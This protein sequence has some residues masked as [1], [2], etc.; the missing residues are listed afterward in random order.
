MAIF[1]KF[2]D[3]SWDATKPSRKPGDE[4]GQ[5]E[6][7]RSLGVGG[8][9]EVYLVKHTLQN[10]Y[11]AL[12]LFKSEVM[13]KQF[14][15]VKLCLQEVKICSSIRHQ[16]LVAVHGAFYDDNHHLAYIV[17][18]YIEGCSLAKLIQSQTLTVR[19]AFQMALGI[20]EALNELDKHNYAHCDVKPENIMMGSKGDIKL[21]DFGIAGI[22]RQNQQALADISYASLFS[23]SPY[24]SPELLQNANAADFRSDIFS[25]GATLYHAVSGQRP[26]DGSSSE[27]I[28]SAIINDQPMPLLGKSRSLKPEYARIIEWMME[29][30]PAKRP[31]SYEVLIQMLKAVI[32]CEQV[33]SP[34]T[35]KRLQSLMMKQRL[36]KRV[37]IEPATFKKII[38]YAVIVAA[39]AA[40]ACL[41]VNYR[42][43]IR[44]KVASILGAAKTDQPKSETDSAETVNMPSPETPSPETPSPEY[45]ALQQE[46][47]RLL[48]K[49]HKELND[50]TESNAL[51]KEF[52]DAAQ[53]GN[54]AR[55]MEMN[56]RLEPDTDVKDE[57]GDSPAILAARAGSL[58]SIP[59]PTVRKTS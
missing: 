5:Y 53:N 16:N 57:N 22:I 28:A 31:Q 38:R 37:W 25:L 48:E 44:Q 42:H 24:A 46:R 40:A 43:V 50:N 47:Q 10:T 33:R 52:F 56:I 12:K 4:I 19:E 18:E 51:L 41:L 29:K 8:V 39:V 17:M 9:G 13:E 1:K 7:V 30:D 55:L 11:F 2:N 54:A 21:T 14:D 23:P 32:E 6:V 45:N 26:F 36:I 49:I 35:L 58:A 20:A 34:K 15:I 3:N 27:T 59:T